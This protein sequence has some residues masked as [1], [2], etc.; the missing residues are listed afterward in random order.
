MEKI[1]KKGKRL[2][3]EAEDSFAS[4]CSS[5]T[6][7][8][9]SVCV[10]ILVVVFPLI[11][12]KAYMNIMDVKYICY[13]VSVLG[14]LGLLLIAG[15][16]MM[17]VDCVKY[18]CAYVRRLMSGLLPKNWKKTFL[19]SDIA[20]DFVCLAVSLSNIDCAYFYWGVW[21]EEGT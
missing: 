18:R 8:I 7:G 5:I 6:N 10:L 13:Y 19:L 1:V 20:H 2:Q 11:Y 12:D 3:N 16:G 14:M 9:I 4:V 15:I 21:G 17:A